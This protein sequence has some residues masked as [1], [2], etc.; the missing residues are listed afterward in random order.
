MAAA[1]GPP[2]ARRYRMKAAWLFAALLIISFHADGKNI[3][4]ADTVSAFDVFT[5]VLGNRWVYGCYWQYEDL[6]QTDPMYQ[7]CGTGTA[8]VQVVEETVPKGRQRRSST[9][10]LLPDPAPA[11]RMRRSYPAA[12]IFAACSPADRSGQKSPL[13]S[14]NLNAIFKSSFS[15]N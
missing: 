7:Y 15:N 12:S 9:M 14:A 11:G 3:R 6:F 2:E 10:N 1:V 8:D 4:K 13:L 5:L